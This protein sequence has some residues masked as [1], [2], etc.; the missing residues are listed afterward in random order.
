MN[1]GGTRGLCLVGCKLDGH[2]LGGSLCTFAQ[3]I[4][5]G[6]FQKLELE[7][8]YIPGVGSVMEDMLHCA[9]SFNHS[10]T[11]LKLE[12][13]R[14]EGMQSD[15]FLSKIFMGLH[16]KSSLLTIKLMHTPWGNDTL[17]AIGNLLGKPNC[18]VRSLSI[19]GKTELD[20]CTGAGTGGGRPFRD[21]RLL[22]GSA[23]P[24]GTL[25]RLNL[26]NCNLGNDQ[27]RVLMHN[28]RKFPGLSLLNLSS[29]DITSFGLTKGP[30]LKPSYKLKTLDLSVNPGCM[31]PPNRSNANLHLKK[32][33]DGIVD[34]LTT[35]MGMAELAE[36]LRVNDYRS[37]LRWQINQQYVAGKVVL[38]PTDYLYGLLKASCPPYEYLHVKK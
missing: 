18:Q 29:N 12:Q 37:A 11:H 4:A 34:I 35:I 6:S 21:L 2:G 10:L 22:V 28:L 31:E 30:L 8:V 1:M 3:A 17:E 7:G 23:C 38:C 27:Y 15:K 25:Q 32:L 14:F 36:L 20:K 24:C 19:T 5:S 26:E 16:D 13:V 33:E 9:F